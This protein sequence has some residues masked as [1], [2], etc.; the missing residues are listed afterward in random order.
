MYVVYP[1]TDGLTVT[2]ADVKTGKSETVPVKAGKAGPVA[3]PAHAF[4][5]ALMF[6]SFIA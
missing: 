3:V 6:N 2:I 5:P 1:S 4:A